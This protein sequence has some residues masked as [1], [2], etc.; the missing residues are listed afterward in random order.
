MNANYFNL[1]Q[2]N[3]LRGQEVLDCL[4]CDEL[5]YKAKNLMSNGYTEEL[6]SQPF[7]SLGF[8]F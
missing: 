4:C 3:D 8:S 7:F 6:E 1:L 2:L 5:G